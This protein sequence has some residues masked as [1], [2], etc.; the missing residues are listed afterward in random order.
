MFARQRRT[1]RRGGYQPP[2]DSHRESRGTTCRNLPYLDNLPPNSI[3]KCSIVPLSAQC[4]DVVSPMGK[5]PDGW[6]PPLR[7]F[8]ISGRVIRWHSLRRGGATRRE[9]KSNDRRGRSHHNITAIS[10][11]PT[12]Q[13]FEQNRIGQTGVPMLQIYHVST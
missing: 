13:I 6:Y 11:P 7:R 5:Q 1:H 3:A 12:L 2:G 10:R 9:S 8:E 4:A